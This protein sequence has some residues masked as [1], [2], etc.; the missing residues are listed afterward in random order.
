MVR[1]LR[2]VNLV[3]VAITMTIFW[4]S[5]VQAIFFENKIEPLLDTLL[6]TAL[7]LMTILVTAGGYVI[8][9]LQDIH[10]DKINKPHLQSIDHSI[11][12]KTAQIAYFVLN[13]LAISISAFI[14]Y[15]T[16]SFNVM[17]L[18]AACILILWLYSKYFKSTILMGNVI[19]SLLIGLIPFIFIIV[20]ND[21]FG[22]LFEINKNAYFRAYSVILS[23]TFFAFVANLIREIVKDCE[24][25]DG[26]KQAG[27]LTLATGLGLKKADILSQFLTII[28][29]IAT[30][31][32]TFLK[33]LFTNLIEFSTF[34]FIVLFPIAYL[35][36][37]LTGQN[38]QKDKYTAIS[39]HLKLILV[40]G[41]VYLI[42]HL[43]LHYA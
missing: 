34:L 41:L 2:P 11:S 24:D 37:L 28:L 19:V 20:E 12:S 40:L 29:F 27:V 21:S 36:Y 10:T 39:K 43:R 8:N 31:L 23:F 30:I 26:D 5:L 1:M 25:L 35:F 14:C 6:F 7:M 13:L 15:K 17:A 33:D 22:K 38:R 3:I 4:F 18:C 16:Q 42:I 9:D 32:W